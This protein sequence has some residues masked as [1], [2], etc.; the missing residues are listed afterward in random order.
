MTY[1]TPHVLRTALEDR[2]QRR[3][4]EAG[5]SLDRLRRRVM[6][7][8]IVARL[9]VAEPGR[10]VLKGGMALEVRL[11][12]DARLT[13]DLDLGLRADVERGADI[14]ERLV[15]VL[16]VDRDGDGFEFAART[17]E[18]LGADGAGHVTWRVNVSARLAGRTFGALRLDVSPR[19]HELLVTEQVTLPNSLAFAGI[20]PVVA[21]IVD[22]NR[23]AAEKLHAMVRDFG[24]R[25]NTRVRDLVDVV[26]LA[27]NDLLTPSRLSE[28]V[29]QV[30]SE[31]NGT[32]PPA[33]LPV[34]PESWPVRYER[35][36][37]QQGVVAQEY[38]AARTLVERLWAQVAGSAES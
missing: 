37:A 6:F 17:P 26:L 12:D 25:E 34:F 21:E 27:E 31:R 24:D 9:E 29:R 1:G 36:V 8:R 32:A 3:S 18:I 33:K 5:I 11:G 35:L 30:W 22:V 10:W 15:E 19:A 38:P 4:Q 14:H 16:A 13:K 7:E 23:H 2:L 20:P 28:T